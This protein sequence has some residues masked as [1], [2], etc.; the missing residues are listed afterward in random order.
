M[1][2]TES[3]IYLADYI[4]DSRNFDDCVFLRY[5]F[6]DK[7]PQNMTVEDRARHLW[8]TIWISFDLTVKSL[9]DES[10][11]ISPETVDARNS[12]ICKLK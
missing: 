1:T 7:E 2:L 11:P 8:Q 4:D 3:L 6:W 10:M 9:V 5:Y 12:M